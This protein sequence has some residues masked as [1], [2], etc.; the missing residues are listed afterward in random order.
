[1]TNR[2]KMKLLAAILAAAGV[3]CAQETRRTISNP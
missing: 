2:H 3:L 1:M